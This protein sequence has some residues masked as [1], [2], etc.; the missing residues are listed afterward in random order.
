MGF[1]RALKE[2]FGVGAASLLSKGVDIA[3]GMWVPV[4]SASKEVTCLDMGQC[5]KAGIRK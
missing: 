5:P 4:K 2:A 1:T 3:V